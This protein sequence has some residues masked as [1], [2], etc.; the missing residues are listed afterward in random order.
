MRTPTRLL[1]A[2][3]LAGPVLLQGQQ[4]PAAFR[5]GVDLLTVEVTVVDR[6]GAP[7]RD[8]GPADFAVK[9]DGRARKVVFADFR[10][11]SVPPAEAGDVAV[12]APAPARAAVAEP[13]D[14][15]IV[16]FVVDRD[17]I[18]PG[19]ELALLDTAGTVLDV[20]GP[21]DAAGLV[22][23]PV[24]SVELT[25]DADRVRKAMAMMTGTRPRQS[26][27]QD[28]RMSWEEALGYEQRNP[29]IIA[30]VVERECSNEKPPEGLRILCPDD[31]ILQ[32][33][34]MLTEGRAHV[35]TTMSVLENLA[36]RLIPLR[37]SKHIVFLSGGLMFGLDLQTYFDRFARKAALGGTRVSVVHIDQP[38]SDVASRKVLTSAFGGRDQ[39]AG[40]TVITGK[41]GGAFF[42]GV[43]RAAG[44][45]RQIA[46]SISNFYVLGL[47]SGPAD[48]VAEPRSLD[49]DVARP[50]LTVRAAERVAG[51]RPRDADAVLALL[52]QP[53]DVS[54]LAVGAAAY[55]TRGTD[56]TL[57]RVLLSSDVT[58]PGLRLPIDWGYAVLDE[59]NVVSTGRYRVEEGTP[60]PW[61]VTTSAKLQPGRYR[62]RVV[63][64]D[65]NSRAGVADVPLTVGLR[66]AGPLQLSDLVVGVADGNGRL[67]PRAVLT[68]GAPLSALVEVMSSD[69][70][71]LQTARVVMEI[72][73]AGSAEPVRRVLMAA[74]GGDTDTVLL[75]VAEID[76]AAL[77]PGRYAASAVAVVDNQPVG[78]VSRPFEVRA[79][80]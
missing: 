47:E 26:L 7:V 2:V 79:A 44:V 78:R 34:N 61:T 14:G 36:E 10:G 77:A 24:G 42:M 35:Q 38:D 8:L 15:R 71:P 48:A 73:P 75:N 51:L 80:Q 76:T 16:V 13:V 64:S 63:A 46:A 57:L 1:P 3:L 50:G 9:V 25:R 72:L 6:D 70:S 43:G 28:R 65:A 52:R 4:P 21:G 67:L 33:R 27:Y 11:S 66:S 56:E 37:G 40:L 55:T 22:G 32:A 18:A 45:F 74:R 31:L 19:N 29:R 12:G 68:Q 54:E 69:P 30:E 58:A 59:D 5:A 53:T 62:L 39:T 60:G 17:S 23:I 20:L 49:V 41:T